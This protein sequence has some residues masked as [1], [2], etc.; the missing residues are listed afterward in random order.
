MFDK[1]NTSKA[2]YEVK[3]HGVKGKIGPVHFAYIIDLDL[4]VIKT[5]ADDTKTIHVADS[6]EKSFSLQ[7]AVDGLVSSQIR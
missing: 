7:E 6:E 1:P 3:P 4:N 2:D 5:F